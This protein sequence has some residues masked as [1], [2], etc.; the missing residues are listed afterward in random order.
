[1][2]FDV[3]MAE[4]SELRVE[5]LRVAFADGR[6]EVVRGVSL[7]VA[8]GGS[9]GLVGE[10][11]SGKSLTCRA[12]LGLLPRGAVAEGRILVDGVPVLDGRQRSRAPGE[13]PIGMVFQ[14]PLAALNPLLRVGTSVAQVIQARD[15]KDR[16][17]ASKQAVEALGRVGIR[18]PARQA[19]RYPHQLSGGMRQRVLIA[20]ALALRPQ[21]LLADEPTSAVDVLVQAGILELLQRLRRET[22]MSLLIVS[23]DLGVVANVCERIA[24]MYAG[25]IVEEGE[26]RAVLRSPAHPYTRGLVGS[27]PT[28]AGGRL[29]GIPGAP[30]DAGAATPGCRF[31]SRCPRVSADCVREPIS[32]DTIADRRVRC[33]HPLTVAEAV[34]G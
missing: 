32:I 3:S 1:M 27:L 13:A 7:T 30:P 2:S 29:I 25:E 19:R 9:L 16:R 8:G 23:H 12:I 4:R 34:H 5:G 26:T 17:T 24:V 20:M 31:A 21:L 33:I 15:G 14:D 22:G 28:A 10:S 11:G 6:R 18:D